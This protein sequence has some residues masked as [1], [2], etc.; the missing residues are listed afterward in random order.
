MHHC[1][2]LLSTIPFAVTALTVQEDQIRAGTYQSSVT[3]RALSAAH[4]CMAPGNGHQ[5]HSG[6][7]V[8]ERRRGMTVLEGWNW[9]TAIYL[10]PDLQQD[11]HH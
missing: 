6:E 11:S 8:L 1:L 2:N 10:S 7:K 9:F 3:V 4:L 5:L